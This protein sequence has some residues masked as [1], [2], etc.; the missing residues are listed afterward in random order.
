MA[1]QCVRPTNIKSPCGC[2]QLRRQRKRFFF[3]GLAGLGMFMVLSMTV[4]VVD[5]QNTGSSS[6]TTTTSSLARLPHVVVWI[7]NNSVSVDPYVVYVTAALET[8]FIV[9]YARNEDE[10]SYNKTLMDVLLLPAMNSTKDSSPYPTRYPSA[11]AF[12]EDGGSILLVSYWNKT[13]IISY[14]EMVLTT[15][16]GASRPPVNSIQCNPSQEP[17]A[18]M[19]LF[20]SHPNHIPVTLRG[21]ESSGSGGINVTFPNRLYGTYDS[22][23]GIYILNCSAG[24]FL[25]M[26]K[27]ESSGQPLVEFMDRGNG[28]VYYISYSWDDEGGAPKAGWNEL[29]AQLVLEAYSRGPEI[30]AEWTAAST[31]PASDLQPGDFSEVTR[32]VSYLPVSRGRPS[33]TSGGTLTGLGALLSPVAP[34]NPVKSWSL[35]LAC[36]SLV[37]P[38]LEVGALWVAFDLGL[39]RPVV[40]VTVQSFELGSSSLAS[41]TVPME[42]RVSNLTFSGTAKSGVRLCPGAVLKY[43]SSGAGVPRR[44]ACPKS[45]A[46]AL[47]GR[48]VVVR[49]M[50]PAG[51]L[52]AAFPAAR[53]CGVDVWALVRSSQGPV[54]LASRHRPVCPGAPLS[55]PAAFRDIYSLLPP[56]NTTGALAV[57]GLYHDNRQGSGYGMCAISFPQDGPWFTIDL[58]SPQKVLWVELTKSA[59]E[60]FDAQ[61]Q[62]VYIVVH[63][64]NSISSSSPECSDFGAFN[65]M[66]V[67]ALPTC[68]GSSE[69]LGD[70]GISLNPG[71]T[72]AAQC[73]NGSFGRFV[74]IYRPPTSRSPQ[75]GYTGSLRLCEVDV[76]VLQTIYGLQQVSYNRPVDYG[77]NGPRAAV[78]PDATSLLNGNYPLLA[79]GM[80]TDGLKPGDDGTAQERLCPRVYDNSTSG[81]A[82]YEAGDG[83]FLVVDLGASAAG[84]VVEAVVVTFANS[85]LQDPTSATPAE[86]ATYLDVRVGSQSAGSLYNANATGRENPPCALHVG[87]LSGLEP[88]D[89]RWYLDSLHRRRYSCPSGAQAEGG[90]RYV[91]LMMPRRWQLADMVSKVAWGGSNTTTGWFSLAICEVDVYARVAAG[92]SSSLTLV[93]GRHTTASQSSSNSA[94]GFHLALRNPNTQARIDASTHRLGNN[95]EASYCALADAL[96]SRNYW[97]MDLQRMMQVAFVRVLG[98]HAPG[99]GLE[100]VV[101]VLDDS[102]DGATH[103]GDVFG[104]VCSPTTGLGGANKTLTTEAGPEGASGE[105]ACRDAA[106]SGY[107]VGRYVAIYVEGTYSGKQSLL[108]CQA[109][110]YINGTSG[111]DDVYGYAGLTYVP[112]GL[113]PEL[114]TATSRD[115]FGGGVVVSTTD[116]Q[117]SYVIDS[118]DTAPNQMRRLLQ[119]QER[120]QLLQLLEEPSRTNNTSKRIMKTSTSRNNSS[121]S[122]GGSS[123]GR[124]GEY[125][126][127]E[128]S[129]N[130]NGDNIIT[131]SG[132]SALAGARPP[133]G[134]AATVLAGWSEYDTPY[135]ASYDGAEAAEDSGGVQGNGNE[136]DIDEGARCC[137]LGGLRSSGA[138]G[139]TLSHLM[140]Q[141]PLQQQQQRQ[142]RRRQLWVSSFISANTTS[143]WRVDLGRP[144]AVRTTVLYTQSYTAQYI[145]YDNIQILITNSSNAMDGAVVTSTGSINLLKSSHFFECGGATGRYVFVNRTVAFSLPLTDIVVF[146]DSPSDLDG[147]VVSGRPTSQTGGV[148]VGPGG[149]S[150]AVNGLNPRQAN[151]TNSLN[152]SPMAMSYYGSR[153]SSDPSP[154]WAV[155]LG[156]ALPLTAVQITAVPED[157]GSGGG[158]GAMALQGYEIRLSNTSAQTGTEGLVAVGAGSTLAVAYGTTVLVQLPY[159]LPAARQL[160]VR[161]PPQTDN[162]NQTLSLGQVVVLTNTSQLEFIVD[163]ANASAQPALALSRLYDSSMASA[164]AAATVFDSAGCGSATANASQQAW[165]TLDLGASPEI[166]RVELVNNAVYDIS[167]ELRLGNTEV[168]VGG[169]GSENPV[170]VSGPILLPT[171]VTSVHYLDPPGFG[172]FLTVQSVAA[173]Y[174]LA[175][176]VTAFGPTP[177]DLVLLTPSPPPSPSPSPSL[178]P[179]PSP[180]PAPLMPSTSRPAPPPS[181]SPPRNPS[182]P[183]SRNPLPPPSPSPPP[184]SPL[185]YQVGK[186][187]TDHKAVQVAAASTI[188]A[189]TTVT[190][191]ASV[192]ASIAASTATAAATTAAASGAASGVAGGVGSSAISTGSG[193]IATSGAVTASIFVTHLQFFALT[194]YAATNATR[195]YRQVNLELS[196]FNLGFST[197]AMRNVPIHEEAAYNQIFNNVAL[198]AATVAAHYLV[199]LLFAKWSAL[200]DWTLPGWFAFPFLEIFVT[201]FTLSSLSAAA[202]VLLGAAAVSGHPRPAVVGCVVVLFITTF[203][204]TA[205]WIVARV[206]IVSSSLGLKFSLKKQTQPRF[207]EATAVKAADDTGSNSSSDRRS[208]GKRQRQPVAEA[209]VQPRNSGGTGGP[210]GGRSVGPRAS[211]VAVPTVADGGTANDDANVSRAVTA[212]SIVVL[213]HLAGSA[214]SWR[215]VATDEDGGGPKG[216]NSVSERPSSQ[217]TLRAGSSPGDTKR[218]TKQ[219]PKTK[220][221]GGEGRGD[222][223]LTSDDEEEVKKHSHGVQGVLA[224]MY[225]G[226]WNRDD[227]MAVSQKLEPRRTRKYLAE[228]MSLRAAARCLYLQPD[229]DHNLDPEG[230]NRTPCRRRR[231]R[232]DDSTGGGADGGGADDGGVDSVPGGSRAAT[233]YPPASPTSGSETRPLTTQNGDKVTRGSVEGPMSSQPSSLGQGAAAS[234]PEQGSKSYSAAAAHLPTMSKPGGKLGGVPGPLHPPWRPAGAA[235]GGNGNGGGTDGADGGRGGQTGGT[236]SMI[237][238]KASTA[239]VLDPAGMPPPPQAPL[240]PAP[241]PLPVDSPMHTKPEAASTG[242]NDPQNNEDGLAAT[243][244]KR[245][246]RTAAGSGGGRDDGLSGDGSGSGNRGD[247]NGKKG[248]RFRRGPGSPSEEEAVAAGGAGEGDGG[249]VRGKARLLDAETTSR[250]FPASRYTDGDPGFTFDIVSSTKST[251]RAAAAAASVPL[252]PS[253]SPTRMRTRVLQSDASAAASAA[254]EQPSG[255]QS[256]APSVVPEAA[257]SAAPEAAAFRRLRAKSRVDI[258][259]PLLSFNVENATI[260]AI[261]AE[262]VATWSGAPPNAET[263]EEL[264]RRMVHSWMKSEAADRAPPSTAV[265]PQVLPP[266]ESVVNVA[267]APTAALPPLPP[268]PGA[269]VQVVGGMPGSLG[270]VSTSL[271]ASAAALAPAPGSSASPGANP[272][273]ISRV[274]S[275]PNRHQLQGDT[276]T[277]TSTTNTN[278]NHHH[279]QGMASRLAPSAAAAAST[280]TAATG[281]PL[282][283]VM[284]APAPL[285]PTLQV[286]GAPQQSLPGLLSP[287]PSPPAPPPT[288]SA[289]GGLGSAA[290]P[291]PFMPILSFGVNTYSEA[292]ITGGG[293]RAFGSRHSSQSSLAVRPPSASKA[294]SRRS[295]TGEGD[296]DDGFGE[297]GIPGVGGR[298]FGPPRRK[299][300]GSSGGGARPGGATAGAASDSSRPSSSP[301]L[302]WPAPRATAAIAPERAPPEF[303]ATAGAAAVAAVATAGGGV[304]GSGRL[305]GTPDRYDNPDGSRSITGDSGAA[306]V[307]DDDNN[308]DDDKDEGNIRD[309]GGG[310]SD[311]GGGEGEGDAKLDAATRLLLQRMEVFERYGLTFEE[312]QGHRKLAMTF[313]AAFLLNTLLPGAL[314]GMQ[315]G[316]KLTPG[317]SAALGVNVALLVFKASYAL[318]VTFIMP[319]INI[320]LIGAEVICSWLETV[321]VMCIVLITVRSG[322]ATKTTTAAGQSTGIKAAGDTMLVCELIVMVIQIFTMFLTAVVPGVM[323]IFETIRAKLG[324][325]RNE[326]TKLHQGKQQQ[327]E[328]PAAERPGGVQAAASAD[329][330]EAAG[331]GRS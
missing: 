225:L 72:F 21:S 57:D 89:E 220:E 245:I 88:L 158:S 189:T 240:P 278:N 287:A 270:N 62:H 184:P 101:R 233:T 320:V 82:P 121:S 272:Q 313:Y 160:I 142:R 117:E 144:Q 130:I 122:S 114:K 141:Q 265:Q 39:I 86:V 221:E 97:V 172:R 151:E 116:Y 214:N 98:P 309:G 5:A 293:P 91:V 181:P 242:V 251:S 13:A 193:A 198:I 229:P 312:N 49:L 155:D 288:E 196:W 311:G 253:A 208:K 178:S 147:R 100:V 306:V 298:R 327:Q 83:V 53:L 99:S 7:G 173:G 118:L 318:Y 205:I 213:S 307:I 104:P 41:V 149:S 209:T 30:A 69:S 284:S 295:V 276:S 330:S 17:Q 194:P 266:S 65:E 68:G 145:E 4:T 34:F 124:D 231:Y 2:P 143:M 32:Q 319:Y 235:T 222:T 249:V 18:T 67:F 52:A 70:R 316:A 128:H 102:W 129:S 159:G 244:R 331:L 290:V 282:P 84:Y 243:S 226:H 230:D 286:K 192:A 115:F 6:T 12:L 22:P 162:S 248:H 50:D 227:A 47:L 154:W 329:L 92:A 207:K 64:A 80:I 60:Q 61:L 96:P 236:R 134:A 73:G 125:D 322:A 156:V 254:N 303:A 167:V 79:A 186:I 171:S 304:P 271:T 111:W 112:E 210:D 58:G 37:Q 36:H 215:S 66:D 250:A 260:G 263:D 190:I 161:L 321:V 301:G 16:T 24:A 203:A 187:E 78:Q 325:R 326:R 131:G 296:D 206:R 55:L 38:G 74:T 33:W 223:A 218:N 9:S 294:G 23:R 258:P 46:P 238:T 269:R 126:V 93:T 81:P 148:V 237:G 179:S 31:T 123:G 182:P 191:A 239:K 256:A 188:A 273:Q 138:K 185:V 176:C 285:A 157:G 163:S 291:P 174:Q 85:A 153:T 299:G 103:P 40:R 8:K 140:Q 29:L 302:G 300:A 212:R 139:Q 119:Q 56:D 137:G 261:A 274:G 107:A 180:P 297:G 51:E 106:S 219:D 277:T 95:S 257:E 177:F 247:T 175:A 43:V 1:D 133:D 135:E 216:P 42:V 292:Y 264:Q 314:L 77:P 202:A 108:L 136:G 10:V 165:I 27:T 315:T 195:Q 241:P 19:A 146:M 109:Y 317:S 127:G 211:N 15:P 44:V 200:R 328:A 20:E 3:W 45:A 232:R 170:A 54:T 25:A 168:A 28:T 113:I 183:P 267:V 59:E 94:G 166:S 11:A 281:S 279:H 63:G 197:F 268:R 105:V 259:L 152:G 150:N 305:R 323:T 324:S 204:V 199:L 246:V 283:S 164:S 217:G 275:P 310:G 120:D 280:A 289:V 201:A 76:Y 110:V 228:R 169:D 26:Y 35:S 255:K 262:V 234:R 252:Q 224:W 75:Y 132:R 14:T 87:L 90:A 308:G 48:Y 71:S